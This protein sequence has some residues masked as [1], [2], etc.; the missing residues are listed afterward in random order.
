MWS[1]PYPNFAQVVTYT[2]L[3]FLNARRTMQ[4]DVGLHEPYLLILNVVLAQYHQIV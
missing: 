3:S 4:D 2:E 1:Y